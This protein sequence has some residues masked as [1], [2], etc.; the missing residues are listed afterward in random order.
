M[1]QNILTETP[2]YLLQKPSIRQQSFPDKRWNDKV[3][4]K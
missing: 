1:D 2:K 3:Y 4:K